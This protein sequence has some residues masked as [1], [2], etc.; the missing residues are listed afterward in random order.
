[1]DQSFFLRAQR[2]FEDSRPAPVAHDML[3]AA[4]AARQAASPT[5]RA[6]AE[7]AFGRPLSEEEVLVEILIGG[8]CWREAALRQG[9]RFARPGKE[10]GGNGS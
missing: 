7:R 3:T 10:R 9:G 2:M 6:Q 5:A 1:M 8:P 4:I